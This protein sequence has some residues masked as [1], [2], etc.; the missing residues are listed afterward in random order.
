MLCPSLIPI[1]S[2]I[3]LYVFLQQSC[4][5]DKIT[6]IILDNKELSGILN[7]TVYFITFS[8]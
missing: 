8:S 2:A 1:I 3:R 4:L 5:K 7:K 6:W